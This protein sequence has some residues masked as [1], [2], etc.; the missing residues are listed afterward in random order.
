MSDQAWTTPTQIDEHVKRVWLRGDLLR[1]PLDGVRYP[2]ELPLRRPDSRALSDR[3]AEVQAW[4]RSLQSGSRE[5]RGFGYDIVWAQVNNR[6]VGANRVPYRVVVPTRDDALRLIG[7]FPEAESFA[8]L[9]AVTLA[10]FPE[11]RE[12]IGRKPLA[13]LEHAAAWE[14]VLRVLAWFRRNPRPGIYLRQLD[15]ATVDTKFIESRKGLLAE[16]LDLVLPANA[17]D[18]SA[19]GSRFFEERYGL[20]SKPARVR[21]RLLDDG[22]F[23][24]G[25]SDLAVPVPEFER[26]HFDVARVF[27]TENDANGLAFPKV[28]RSLVIF[29]LGYGVESLSDAAWL[30]SK[31]LYY[32]GDIDTHGFAMLDRLRRLFPHVSSL[33]MDRATLLAHRDLWTLEGEPHR[34]PLTRL[35]P[36]EGALYADL[37]GNRL[38]TGVRLEQERIAFGH[39]ERALSELR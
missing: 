39:L 2:L 20:L 32:W 18:E 21:F 28:A 15:I 19:K 36:A 14:R 25:F 33:L 30:A 29:G 35:S 34:E 12:W 23:M 7:A 26:A 31:R 22:L 9:A 27:I 1:E 16:L 10:E 4:I 11:L 24:G 6:V 13:L 37:R 17:I 5:R 38:G 3:F 8:R